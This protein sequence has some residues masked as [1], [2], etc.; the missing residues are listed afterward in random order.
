MLL[1]A[2]CMNGK[3][4]NKKNIKNNEYDPVGEYEGKRPLNTP[5]EFFL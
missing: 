1:R 4:S 2:L 5:Y 3:K